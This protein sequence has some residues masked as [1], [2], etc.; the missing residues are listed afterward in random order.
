MSGEGLNLGHRQRAA[1]RIRGPRRRD[2]FPIVL[3]DVNAESDNRSA[4]A[5]AD[6][7]AEHPKHVPQPPR[8]VL[9]I[10]VQRDGNAALPGRRGQGDGVA[11]ARLPGRLACLAKLPHSGKI[12]KRQNACS[13]L[14]P[15]RRYTA[16]RTGACP[17]QARSTEGVMWKRRTLVAM[18]LGLVGWQMPWPS[19]PAPGA[20]GENYKAIRPGMALKEVEAILGRRSDFCGDTLDVNERGLTATGKSSVK[21]WQG[22]DCLICVQLNDMG[23]VENSHFTPQLT[24]WPALG[25]DAHGC[26]WERLRTWPNR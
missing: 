23:A 9:P 3:A 20:N 11:A 12:R 26:L 5:S 16:A 14:P 15:A 17:G 21:W 8:F 19:P 18:C 1:P 2:A 13:C 22:V 24:S 4:G 7:T 10:N 25:P 6:G